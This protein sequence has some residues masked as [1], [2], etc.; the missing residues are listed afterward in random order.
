MVGVWSEL[1]KIIN[2]LIKAV[3]FFGNIVDP[4]ETWCK[5]PEYPWILLSS[6]GYWKIDT[7]NEEFWKGVF[8][9]WDK[10]DQQ[11]RRRTPQIRIAWTLT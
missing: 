1:M 3:E 9:K 10:V 7:K 5:H 6:K 2:C 11:T 4:P 8:E